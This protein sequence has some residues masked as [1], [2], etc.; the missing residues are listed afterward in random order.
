MIHFILQLLAG[1][2]MV[3][4]TLGALRQANL[5]RL[6]AS[7]MVVHAGY[8]LGGAS[9]SAGGTATAGWQI[10]VFLFVSGSLMHAGVFTASFVVCKASG[11][12]GLSA[13]A[14]L[15]YRAPLAAA[16]LLILIVSLCGLPLS[17][18]WIG[19]WMLLTGAAQSGDYTLVVM[20]LISTF[21]AYFYYFGLIRHMFM[22][23]FDGR[24]EIRINIM[25][26]SAIWICA[27]MTLAGGIFPSP[28]INLLE[29]LFP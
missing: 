5:K 27:L 10:P 15:Y 20:M 8:V 6:L 9:L 12:E 23:T 28:V 7:G 3:L 14:G 2:A 29:R 21:L 26:H 22:R 16:A 1:T 4:G 18:G 11:R 24:E 17:A 19:K 13:L 25:P